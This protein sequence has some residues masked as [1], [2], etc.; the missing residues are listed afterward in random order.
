MCSQT[1]FAAMNNSVVHRLIVAG[2]ASIRPKQGKPVKIPVYMGRAH[3]VPSEAEG[4]LAMDTDKRKDRF[5][6]GC[7]GP[8]CLLVLRGDSLT[9]DSADLGIGE[10]M[11]AERVEGTEGSR[12]GGKE[13]RNEGEGD[14]E[15]VRDGVRRRIE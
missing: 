1:E 3:E 15:K 9:I 13:R 7:E 2:T 4:L 10:G 11:G 6:Q 12:E 14:G 8:E 5:L